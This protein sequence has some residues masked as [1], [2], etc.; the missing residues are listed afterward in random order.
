MEVFKE[1]DFTRMPIVLCV[2]YGQVEGYQPRDA[3]EYEPNTYLDGV[4]EKY[5]PND[6]EFD[7]S[8]RMKTL[9]QNKDFGPYATKWQAS[10][11]FSWFKS[12]HRR[13]FRE[14]PAIDAYGN[15]IGLNFDRV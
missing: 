8:E 1:K 4:M 7:V 12:Y 11:M 3:V 5:I 13:Q 10:Y 2:T 6:Y 15:L 14:T 9:Y